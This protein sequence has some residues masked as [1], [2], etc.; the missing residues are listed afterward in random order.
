MKILLLN[1]DDFTG[2]AAIA[3]RRLLKALNQWTDTDAHMLVQQS[4]SGQ[5]GVIQL[6]NSWFSKKIAFLNFV[7]ERLYFLYF[8][9]SKIVRFAF[10]PAKFGIDI[11]KNKHIADADIIHLHWTN[12]GFLS[13][14]SIQKLVNTGKPIVWTLHDM[15][16]FTGGCHHSGLCENYQQSCGNCNQFLKNPKSNDLSNEIWKEKAKVFSEANITVVTC[17]QWLGNRAAIS[18]LLKNKKVIAIPNPIDTHIFKPIHF[19][20]ALNEFGLDPKKKYILFAAM[21]IQAAGKGFSYFLEALNHLKSKVNKETEIEILLFG[22]ANTT[23]FDQLPFKVHNLATISNQETIV[24]AYNAATV[25]VIPSLEENLPNTIMESLAC[26]TPAVGFEVGGIPEMIDH[27]SNGYLAKYK[28]SEDLARGIYW[29]LFEANQQLITE[30]AVNKVLSSY[31]EKVVA[32]RY[33]EVYQ[34]LI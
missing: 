32:Q 17:S 2:G 34:S 3:C 13:I 19:S 10:N 16:A 26:G 27:K 8:E 9:K 23:D 28:S 4:K 7:L 22:Q 6:N 29:V 33:R 11:S 30:N 24:K 20:V 1:T 18:S 15:W 14:D 25:F 21:R 12:F 31:S 5:E